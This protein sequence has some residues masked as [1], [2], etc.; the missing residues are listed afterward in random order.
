M[1]IVGEYAGSLFSDMLAHVIQGSSEQSSNF[2]IKIP[3]ASNLGGERSKFSISSLVNTLRTI[4]YSLNSLNLSCEAS[5]AAGLT[6][7]LLILV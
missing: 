7:C 4:T 6:S 3:L 2:G 1:M 5:S